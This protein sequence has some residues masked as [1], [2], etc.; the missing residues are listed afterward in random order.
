MRKSRRAKK[1][2]KQESAWSEDSGIELI[3]DLVGRGDVRCSVL[4]CH[5]RCA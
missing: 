2:Q 1:R 4:Y 5:V 3:F